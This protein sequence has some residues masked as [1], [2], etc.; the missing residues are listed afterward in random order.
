M[1]VWKLR[2]RVY[3]GGCL[4][5]VKCGSWLNDSESLLRA[6]S[7]RVAFYNNSAVTHCNLITNDRT[8]AV[9]KSRC[10]AWRAV[11]SAVLF[12]TNLGVKKL[13]VC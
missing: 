4:L 12:C 1:I 3:K 10:Y 5:R 11:L 6:K 9:L 13:V 7:G 8:T 2:L